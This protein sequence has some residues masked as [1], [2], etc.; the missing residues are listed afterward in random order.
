[1]LGCQRSPSQ[2]TKPLS[3]Y[4]SLLAVADVRLLFATS[5]VGRLPVGMTSLSIVLLT[6]S[7]TGSYWT[8][9]LSAAS[10]AIAAGVVS[11]VQGHLLDRL[12]QTKVLIS[13]ALLFPLAVT[14]LILISERSTD[15]ILFA[16]GSA[17]VGATLPPLYATLR[18]LLSGMSVPPRLAQTAFG[19]DSIMQEVLFLVGPAFVTLLVALRSP[20]LALAIAATFALTGTVAFASLRVSRHAHKRSA[21]STLS[22]VLRSGGLQILL[23]ASLADG[24]VFG[25]LD[26]AMPAFAGLHGDESL[27]GLLISAVA[28]G[29]IAGGVWF[30]ARSSPA[31]PATTLAPLTGLMGFSF[32][33]LALA[34]SFTVII[35]LLLLA[36]FFV[37]PTAAN[38]Y[39]LMSRV[40]PVGSL[41]SGFA[42]ASTAVIAGVTI[43]NLLAGLLVQTV[44]VQ[45]ALAAGGGAVLVC[46]AGILK[47]RAS[48]ATQAVEERRPG[49]Q[50]AAE[51]RP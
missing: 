5:F 48:L 39:V 14:G 27:A 31:D 7:A 2:M 3:K 32:M 11:P 15:V 43:G 6:K 22:R 12:G 29:S 25:T 38:T 47:R 44:D 37:A 36:G 23:V 34:G 8:A 50:P 10:M 18:V 20:A 13:T 21:G 51:S 24:L 16:L 26:V 49:A 9:G 42:W 30:G 17:L 41:S 45:V 46:S 28:L 40:V 35:P 33:L 1:M 19:L 4:T